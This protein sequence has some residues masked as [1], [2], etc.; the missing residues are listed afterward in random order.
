[1]LIFVPL[2]NQEPG[3]PNALV[4]ID[5]KFFIEYLCEIK[6]SDMFVA[7]Y[8]LPEKFFINVIE[9]DTLYLL[10]PLD[11][12][13]SQLHAGVVLFHESCALQDQLPIIGHLALVTWRDIVC[14]NCA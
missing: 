1:M 2:L 13:K 6:Q 7:L 10:Q 8:V 11:S 12:F 4:F 3:K 5:G 9:I 14:Y